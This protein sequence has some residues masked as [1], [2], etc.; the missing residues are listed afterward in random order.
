MTRRP[1]KHVLVCNGA[2]PPK[3]TRQTATVRLHYLDHEK[4]PK[5]SDRHRNV[6]M[7]LPTLVR[8]VD[9]LPDRLLD[10]VE[11]ATYVYAADRS[12]R[13]GDNASLVLD[14]WSRDMHVV[15][16]VRDSEFWNREHVKRSLCDLLKFMTGDRNWTFTF[17][18]GRKTQRAGIFDEPGVVRATPR[19]TK[20]MLFSGGLDSLAGAAGLLSNTSDAVLLVSHRSGDGRMKKTQDDLFQEL[21]QKFPGRAEPVAYNCGLS[22]TALDESQR[23]RGFLYLSLAF[24]VATAVRENVIYAFENGVTAISM[25]ERESLLNAR[26]SRTAHPKALAG[27]QAL[28]SLIAQGD[29]RVANPFLWKTKTD[30]VR[31]LWEAGSEGLLN[32][33]VSC[34][35]RRSLP[36]NATH[37]GVCSQCIDRRLAVYASGLGRV[38][39]VSQYG[40]DFVKDVIADKR[41]TASGSLLDFVRTAREFEQ[42][43]RD[44]FYIA[45]LPELTEVVDFVGEG[46]EAAAVGRLHELHG[47]HGRQIT[48]AIRAIGVERAGESG[49]TTLTRV[50][51][52]PA[53]G[54][55]PPSR[56][57]ELANALRAIPVGAGKRYEIVMKQVLDA[58][59]NPF[60]WN[61]QEQERSGTHVLDIVF[62]IGASSGFFQALAQDLK[63]RYVLFECKNYTDDPANAAV[64]QICSIM[65]P[66]QYATGFVVHRKWQNRELALSRCRYQWGCDRTPMILDDDDLIFFLERREHDDYQSIWK[67]LDDQRRQLVLH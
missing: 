44:D 35:V 58:I 12:V 25:P 29:I 47:L 9:H 11:I 49:D 60:L 42:S 52:D 59:F 24:A 48:H 63:C 21:R 4:P 50:L 34:G 57:R 61:P 2:K 7:E 5:K 62:T 56:F 8:Q 43:S 1:L 27:A 19:P 65:G 20:V 14:A 51:G 33:S 46:D 53:L 31:H 37:C 36:A 41:G 54:L 32:V 55:P 10:L 40:K 18:P 64:D 17:Q 66:R 26:A 3:G 23:T 30:V 45:R 22:T 13:R 6:R 38:D 15:T 39:D 28:F 67:R 16:Q